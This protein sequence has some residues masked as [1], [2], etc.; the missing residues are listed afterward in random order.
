METY[1]NI[2]MATM[3]R[4]TVEL[5]SSSLLILSRKQ[6]WVNKFVSCFNCDSL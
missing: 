5:K 6:W 3:L 4:N 1:V 2:L